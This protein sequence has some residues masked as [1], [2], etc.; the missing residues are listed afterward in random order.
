[1]FTSG[2]EQ[3]SG[4]STFSPVVV[5]PCWQDKLWV[6]HRGRLPSKAGRCP[7]RQRPSRQD[8]PPLG[9]SAP[10]QPS[11]ILKQ[12][13]G[14]IFGLKKTLQGGD[15][16]ESVNRA[17][18]AYLWGAQQMWA[19]VAPDSTR[20]GPG[21]LPLV[22]WAL[23]VELRRQEAACPT[24]QGAGPGRFRGLDPMGR[25]ASPTAYLMTWSPGGSPQLG[26][27]PW[28]K[29][30]LPIVPNQDTLAS[31]PQS[32]LSSCDEPQGAACRGLEKSFHIL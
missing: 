14:K 30:W 12:K 22:E 10:Q 15:L 9:T 28:N 21:S 27:T 5:G 31:C 32:L 4:P 24:G 29:Q 2:P 23:P 13:T 20:V 19:D 17:R 11:H 25:P 1:M 26:D 7:G 3:P 16:G 8:P 6:G 18:P